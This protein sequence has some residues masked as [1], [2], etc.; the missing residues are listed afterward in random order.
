[1]PTY[2]QI[3]SGSDICEGEHADMLKVPMYMYM[4]IIGKLLANVMMSVLNFHLEE[5]D[6]YAD[7]LTAPHNLLSIMD[8]AMPTYT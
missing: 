2:T 1:M 7:M 3:S 8:I 4:E 6:D 5:L